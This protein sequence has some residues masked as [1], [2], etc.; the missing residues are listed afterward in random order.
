MNF[1]DHTT[2]VAVVKAAG[3]VGTLNEPGPFTVF[4][5]TNGAFGML[6]AGTVDNLVKPENKATLTKI[7]TYHVVAGNYD[8]TKLRSRSGRSPAATSRS[9]SARDRSSAIFADAC[10]R[11]GYLK[12]EATR[13]SPSK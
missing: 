8:T 9:I 2:L 11:C 10:F 1:A 4:A 13:S 6:P 5:R 7:L 12:C 3:P